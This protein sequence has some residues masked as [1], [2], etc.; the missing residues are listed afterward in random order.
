[1]DQ[2]I[3]ALFLFLALSTA[4]SGQEM[5]GVVNSPWTG[6]NS[7][8]INPANTGSARTSFNINILAGDFYVNSNYFFIHKKDYRFL[9]LFSVNFDNPQYWYIYQYPEFTYTDTVRY[10]D[11]HNTTKPK[12]LYFNAR[13]AGP[14]AMFRYG[15]HTFSLVTAFRNNFSFTKVPYDVANFMYRGQDYAPQHEISYSHQKFDYAILSWMEIGP[16]YTYTFVRDDDN[17]ISA[18]IMVKLLLGTGASFGTINQVNYMVPNTDSIWF[19]RMDATLGLGLPMNYADNSLS[20]HPFIRGWGLSGDLGV[21]WVHQGTTL[22]GGSSDP[23]VADQQ[24]RYLFKAGVSLLDLGRIS[25]NREVQIDHYVVNDT[26]L[27][28]GLLNFH[29]TSVQQFTRSASYHLMGD[30]LASVTGQTRFGI[31]LPMAFSFQFDYAFG[32]NL[33]LNAT[34]LQGFRIGRPGIKRPAII[35]LTPRYGNRIYEVNLPLSLTDFRDPAIGLSLRI[36]NLVVGTEKLGTF[37][38]LTNVGGMDVYFSL[39]FNLSSPQGGRGSKGG[40]TKGCDSFENYDR[41]RTTRTK[42]KN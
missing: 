31:W 20:F 2:R 42:G 3:F 21:N 41:Y 28:P 26:T 9:G 16:G 12:N 29:A 22:L 35:A 33:Y 23:L 37:L 36:Y 10:L 17:E 30:S 34:Y 39:G 13:I 38:H 15:N 40:R 14:S 11:F 8:M 19:Y 7:A 24:D 6:V 32:K 1:M 25:F 4:G 18:G 27:W 5:L